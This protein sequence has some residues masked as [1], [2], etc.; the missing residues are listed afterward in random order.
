MS[1]PSGRFVDGRALV[2]I[3]QAAARCH[4]SRR[5]VYN[6]LQQ[7]KVEWVRTAG[8]HVRIVEASLFRVPAL[9]PPSLRLKR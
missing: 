7:G 2:T 4:V 1:D 6:W 8:G 5:T 3:L 9:D